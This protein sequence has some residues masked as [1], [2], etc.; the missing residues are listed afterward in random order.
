MSKNLTD[1]AY[2]VSNSNGYLNIR[3]GRMDADFSLHR[4]L[5]RDS[6]TAESRCKMHEG[7]SDQTRG[8]KV[9][10]VDISMK[11]QL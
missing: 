11:I 9:K 3:S 6:Y 8:L 1:T 5:F 10:K 4:H 2:V 7:S